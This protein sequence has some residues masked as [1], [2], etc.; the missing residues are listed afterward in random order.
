ME[1][2]QPVVPLSK[3]LNDKLKRAERDLL[4]TIAE[5]SEQALKNLKEKPTI[6]DGVL[7][8]QTIYLLSLERV[9]HVL[10]ESLKDWAMQLSKEN[11]GSNERE[12]DPGYA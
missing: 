12:R 1:K 8:I 5:V 9:T 10:I 7:M 11:D 6:A 4:L 2:E 3:E